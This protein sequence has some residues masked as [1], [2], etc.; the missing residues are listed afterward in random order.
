MTLVNFAIIVGFATI[1]GMWFE[2]F[3]ENCVDRYYRNMANPKS[4]TSFME[5]H[6][7][8]IVWSLIIGSSFISMAFWDGKS[9]SLHH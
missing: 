4:I 7:G 6:A 8:V 3:V 1:F 9:Y 2:G 5:R